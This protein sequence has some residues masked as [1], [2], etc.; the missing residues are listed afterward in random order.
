MDEQVTEAHLSPDGANPIVTIPCGG[1][2]ADVAVVVTATEYACA[3][4]HTEFRLRRCPRCS[5]T[6]HPPA[7]F[8]GWGVQCVSCQFQAGWPRLE[9]SKVTTGEYA[10]QLAAQKV[11]DRSVAG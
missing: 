4:C 10:A 2:R 8:D 1:C 7:P 6:L 3:S 11:K 5:K 9:S